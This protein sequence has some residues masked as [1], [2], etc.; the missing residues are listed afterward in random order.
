MDYLNI[1]PLD[2]Y[3]LNGTTFEYKRGEIFA[4]FTLKTVTFRGMSKAQIK[5]VRTKITD[6][7]MYTE[8]DVFIPRVY[9]EGLY[10]ANGKFNSYKI[11][12]KG[13][14]NMTFSE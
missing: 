9:A 4:T 14:F 13:T 11:N 8:I 1:P 6:D 2:P 10:K 3:T 12:S 7:G 5:D